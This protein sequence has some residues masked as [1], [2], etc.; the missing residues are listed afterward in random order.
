MHG[1]GGVAG[2]GIGG[3]AALGFGMTIAGIDGIGIIIAGFI[4]WPM[5]AYPGHGMGGGGAEL[6]H[7]LFPCPSVL[8]VHVHDLCHVLEICPSECCHPWTC[9]VADEV[10][11][12][13]VVG[14]CFS[15][16][17]PMVGLV[18]PNSGHTSLPV[19]AEADGCTRD[20]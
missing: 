7:L 18:V 12:S 1:P 10:I 9:S 5:G 16:T 2:G 17:A 14:S 4:I 6:E 15:K 19:P 20:P 11:E 13:F 3:A 8:E